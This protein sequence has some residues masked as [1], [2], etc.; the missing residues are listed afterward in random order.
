[1]FKLCS[2]RNPVTAWTIP[3]RS[4]HDRVRMYS[5]LLLATFGTVDAILFCDIPAEVEL[6]MFVVIS[7]WRGKMEAVDQGARLC[8]NLTLEVPFRIVCRDVLPSS[9]L[10][11][12]DIRA[13]KVFS[14]Q[15][16]HYI[17]LCG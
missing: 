4:G 13:A 10:P 15:L 17:R 5:A 7:D 6:L 11:A 9:T 2:A 14:G 16:S 1:M 12:V 8:A 3:A